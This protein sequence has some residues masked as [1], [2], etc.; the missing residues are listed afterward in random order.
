MTLESLIKQTEKLLPS[1]Q[2]LPRLLTVL[3]SDDA[4]AWDIVDLVKLDAALTTQVLALSNS[5]FYGFASTSTDLEEA[6]NRLGFRELYKL[7]SLVLCRKLIG[8][9]SLEAY[10]LAE[11]QLWE[12]S[13]A[14]AV[15]AE[16][17]AGLAAEDSSL[18]YTV[19]LMH[20]IG[21]LAIN[22]LGSG[23]YEAVYR[24]IEEENLTMLEAERAVMGFDHAE[25]TA[26]LLRHWNFPEE[27]WKPIQHQYV[28]AEAVAHKGMTAVLHTAVYVAAI[29]GTNHGRDAWAF[30]LDDNALKMARQTPES[31]Q[32]IVIQVVERLETVKGLI[33]TNAN[34]K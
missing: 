32:E 24:K 7:V 3:E 12:H 14:T 20:C 10:L 29:T 33:G 5:A 1:P 8:K 9:D 22:Q 17:I 4:C 19:G 21:K 34:N 25:A 30:R 13:L 6:V 26:A 27:A 11:G 2:V 23:H 15:A 31:I 28:P 18:A 16:N